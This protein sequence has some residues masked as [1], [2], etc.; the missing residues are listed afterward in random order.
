MMYEYEKKCTAGN[1]EVDPGVIQIQG[2]S[3]EL[4]IRSEC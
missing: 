4:G 3:G 1:F 2:Q